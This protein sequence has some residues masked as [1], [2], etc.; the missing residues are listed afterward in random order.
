MLSIPQNS[1][2]SGRIAAGLAEVRSR[3]AASTRAA[4]RTEQSVTLLAVSK[5]QPQARIRVAVDLGLREF[6]EN[7]VVEALPKIEA[8]AGLGLT[9]HFIGRVQA[10]K[11]RALATHFDWVHG[12]ERAAIAERLSAQR[13]ADLPPLNICLQVN[14]L[15]D[16]SKA[17]VDPGELP[18][19]IDATRRLPHMKLRGLMCMLPY[20]ADG[21]QQ[22]AGFGRLRKL[23]DA[24]RDRGIVLDTLSM[25]MSADLE[26]AIAQ[27]ATLVRV[28]TALF[29][30]R[31]E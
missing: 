16:G 1:S 10:N 21:A 12:I 19:L 7:Y 15:G 17:G 9:W 2:E 29:G 6:G 24:A 27:G 13:G 18:A 28:G 23:R 25:G 3:I 5:G 8:L 22:A 30:E 20:G 14:V 4:G 31:V 11:T 26:A